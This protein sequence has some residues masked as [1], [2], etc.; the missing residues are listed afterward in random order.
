MNEKNGDLTME[1][2]FADFPFKMDGS[3]V[4][5]DGT[6]VVSTNES[7]LLGMSVKECNELYQNTFRESKD[8][9]VRLD[10]AGS[11]W[12]GRKEKI[13]NYKF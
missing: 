12:Y 9:I 10:A 2:V 6:K 7:K 8:H 5:S 3:V 4:I 1:T 13:R 11:S